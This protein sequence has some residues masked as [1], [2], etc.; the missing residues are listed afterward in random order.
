MEY[1]VGVAVVFRWVAMVGTTEVATE[2]TAARAMPTTVALAVE[3]PCIMECSG[4]CRENPQI[5]TEAR[6]KTHGRPRKCHGYSRGP[7]PNIQIMCICGVVG[8]VGGLW[9]GCGWCVGVLVHTGI[10]GEAFWLLVLQRTH[11]L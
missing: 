8:R 6:G 4:A 5:S 11:Y 3:A 9:V 1:A 7:P 10:A 2:R